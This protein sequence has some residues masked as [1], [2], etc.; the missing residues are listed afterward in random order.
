MRFRLVDIFSRVSRVPAGAAGGLD[1]GVDARG[2]TSSVRRA[3]GAAAPSPRGPP[4][5]APPACSITSGLLTTP[6]RPVPAT[7]ARSTPDSAAT[8]FAAGDARGS[9]AATAGAGA[10]L[11]AA[12]CG[13]AASAGAGV[14]A[15]A[16][17]AP[18]ADSSIS[19]RTS[20]TATTSPSCF[21]WRAN[22][23]ALS[24]GTSTVTLSVSNSTSVSPAATASPSFLSHRATVASTIDSPRGG[25]LIEIIPRSPVTGMG[26]AAEPSRLRSGLGPRVH[27]VRAS[28][29]GGEGFAEYNPRGNP[30]ER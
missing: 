1:G 8:R 27:A 11:E 25:T 20:S 26:F 12:R 5:G 24:A 29:A 19:P 16:C 15:G 23:P 9:E 17:D 6:P 28:R 3:G 10:V 21:T 14:R 18:L 4:P 13:D 2:G 30:C 22:T 7:V